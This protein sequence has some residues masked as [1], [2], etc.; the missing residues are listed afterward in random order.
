MK[1]G[2]GQTATCDS[3]HDTMEC[4]IQLHVTLHMTHAGVHTAT[5]DLHGLL[6]RQLPTSPAADM[7]CK[8]DTFPFLHRYFMLVIA[9]AT[10]CL[11][12][13]HCCCI[14]LV[15]VRQVL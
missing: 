13:R 6:A 12:L 5:C 3:A 4:V 2:V 14:L 7:G 10:H 1:H 15:A 8:V 9:V 11:H